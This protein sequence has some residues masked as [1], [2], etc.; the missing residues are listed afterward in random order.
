MLPHEQINND[1]RYSI[2]D[3]LGKSSERFIIP[4][5]VHMLPHEQ[6]NRFV[7]Q[8]IAIT[9]GE[10]GERSIVPQL[11]QMLPDEQIDS[12]VR[13]RIVQAMQTLA[14]E[15]VDVRSL[16]V[17]LPASDIADHIHDAL[18][19]ISRRVGVRIFMRHENGE[20]RVE[21]VKWNS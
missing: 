15:E 18:W 12:E 7:R 2:A 6:I 10:L 16:A 4:Q 20:D 21:V 19:T 11:L 8:G 9:L 14:Q 3:A 1:V 13:L 5:L 17:L